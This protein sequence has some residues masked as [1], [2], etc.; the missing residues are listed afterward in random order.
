MHIGD[1]QIRALLEFLF[2]PE[3]SS[4]IL[5]E[6]N[7]REVFVDK[8]TAAI[9]FRETLKSAVWIVLSI[10]FAITLAQLN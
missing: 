1:N 9:N 6:V 7:G 8:A 3:D 4:K 2:A 10:C 5:G